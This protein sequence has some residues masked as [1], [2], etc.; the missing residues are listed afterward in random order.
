[1]AEAGGIIPVNRPAR[2]EARIGRAGRF[3]LIWLVAALSLAGFTGW[4]VTRSDALDR[5]R[6]WEARAKAGR[7]PIAWA[8]AA[9]LGMDHLRRQP[10]STEAA[11]LVGRSLARLDQPALAERYLRR[12]RGQSLEDAK[13]LAYAWL[14]AGD[15]ERA[16]AAYEELLKRWPGDV[17]ALRILGGIYYSRIML[18]NALGVSDRLLATPGGEAYGHYLAALVYQLHGD[19]DLA[20]KEYRLVLE[21]DP[22][23][24]I[25]DDETRARFWRDLALALL[26]R[27]PAAVVEL[28]EGKI[29]TYPTAEMWNILGR[30]RF[31]IEDLEG[32]EAA[33]GRA[34]ELDAGHAGS[35]RDRGR[36]ALQR[37]DVA[38]AVRC[39]ERAERLASGDFEG[40]VALGNAYRLAGRREEALKIQA[41]VDRLRQQGAGAARG[42]NSG[43]GDVSMPI[44]VPMEAPASA[45]GDQTQGAEDGT[46]PDREE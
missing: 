15:Q 26:N 20:A 6:E 18:P 31:A 35:W 34:L 30:A 13:A 38:E 8:E 21:R 37:R 23:L 41:R 12:S 42:M 17:E 10:W 39:L 33:F 5:A 24:S 22:G 44:S 11:E 28:V 45:R 46:V 2:T 27:E 14:R 4:L 43:A 1:V 29:D 25:L 36:L 9:S 32:A 16:I 7:D 19:L 3:P 40:L